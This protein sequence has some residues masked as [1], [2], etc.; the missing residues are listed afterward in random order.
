MR[1]S[2]PEAAP[3]ILQALKAVGE[4]LEAEGEAAGIVIV[5]GTA[6]IL[7]GFVERLT[8]D[9]DVIAITHEPRDA[10]GSR[11]GR[12]EPLPQPLTTAIARVAR[13]FNLPET[14]MNSTVTAQW[15]QGLPPGFEERI[16]WQKHGGLVV[17]VADR[18]D[19]IF[20][21]LYA[22]VDS[23]GPES[24]HYQ[25]LP[26]SPAKPRGARGRGNMGKDARHFRWVR[27]HVG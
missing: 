11:I 14:W 15:D 10:S 6:L 17:G 22:A 25:D 2:T 18:R 20:L 21:K 9:V 26:C 5:G 13:D 24:V 23:E 27:R 16:H 7:Q 4:L 3:T 12:A 1:G 8:E 19:L